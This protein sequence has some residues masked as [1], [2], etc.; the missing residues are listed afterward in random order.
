MGSPNCPSRVPA[1][2]SADEVQGLGVGVQRVH[3]IH[4]R[5]ETRGPERVGT[6]VPTVSS[7]AGARVVIFPPSVRRAGLARPPEAH[8]S[9]QVGITAAL[10]VSP[11]SVERFITVPITGGT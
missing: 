10:Q 3:H 2:H 8:E 6:W 7:D 9:V 1:T 11:E 5:V 4:E